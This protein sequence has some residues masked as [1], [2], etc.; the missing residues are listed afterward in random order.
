MRLALC[1]DGLLV[2]KR[3]RDARRPMGAA[4]AYRSSNK[5]SAEIR[6]RSLRAA[7]FLFVASLAGRLVNSAVPARFSSARLG[8][9]M[10]G[11]LLDITVS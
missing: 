9:R 8:G 11:V 4:F 7:A 6:S 2:E 1:S 10:S 3:F 5:S